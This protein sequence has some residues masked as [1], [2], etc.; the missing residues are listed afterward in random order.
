[1][2]RLV[3]NWIAAG[4]TKSRVD[5]WGVS[6]VREA[7]ARVSETTP[8]RRMLGGIVDVIVSS[9]S[10]DLH[11][12]CPR[13]MAYGQALEYDDKW[14]LAA[15]VYQTIVAHA[16]PVEDADL[17]AAAYIQLA[18]CLRTLGDLDAAAAAYD[19]ASRVALAAGDM[20]GVLR[21]RLGDV[22]VAIARGNMPQAESILEDTIASADLSGLPDIRS[23][24]LHER[25]YVAGLRGQ[26]D[27]AIRYAYEALETSSTQRDRDRILS[28]IATA[29]QFLGLLD[30]ARDAYLILATTAQEQY[31]RWT[32]EL[33]LMELAAHQRAELQFDKYRRDLESA[34]FTP[35]LRVTYL[36]HVGRGYHM[37]GNAE[38]G[39]PYLQRAVEM[40]AKHGHNQLLFEA[41]AA[42][43]EATKRHVRSKIAAKI[44][45]DS[46]VQTVI[47][48][49]QDMKQTAG[50]A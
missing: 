38:S 5:S 30:V 33:N 32:S 1:V 21:G 39:I 3:D 49:I 8:I 16:H 45:V 31:V 22:K 35:L 25:A 29:F 20:I 24:A 44:V 28:N 6:A 36:L 2:L 26:H 19:C 46:T 4:A 41:E 43:D 13:L 37:L 14:S 40:A 15:D 12:L 17:V 10:V 7:I 23:R 9:T 42:L 48:A 50:I 27:R 18:F 47:D 11:T 34:D